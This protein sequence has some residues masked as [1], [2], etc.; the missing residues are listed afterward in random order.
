MAQQ[1]SD[2]GRTHSFR[3][4]FSTKYFLLTDQSENIKA[5]QQTRFND[6]AMS[7]IRNQAMAKL[8]G[9]HSILVTDGAEWSHSRSMLRPSF[10]RNAIADLPVFDRHV[11]HLIERIG[12][13]GEPV[14]LQELFAM[15]TMDSA[16]DFMFG[17]TTNTLNHCDPE[18]AKFSDSF[19][20]ASQKVSK[21]M[22]NGPI[23]NMF[24][25]HQGDEANQY[26]RSYVDKYVKTAL[27]DMGR[28]DQ[29]DKQKYMFLPEL[30]KTGASTEVIRDQVMTMFFA[31]RDS[32]TSVMSYLFWQLARKPDVVEKIQAEIYQYFGGG[33][34]PTFE[35]LRDMRYLNWSIKEALRLNP[36]LS[37]NARSAIR[38]TV[39][40]VGGG[41]DG[42][43]PVFCPEGTVVRWITW[44][45]HRDPAVFGD[46]ANEF[47]PGRWEHLKLT[48]EYLPFSGGPRVCI[49]QQFA[50]TQIA[51]VAVRL[52][53]HFKRI[54]ARDDKP[55]T[56][57]LG[58]TMLLQNG[59]WVS[60]KVGDV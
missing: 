3:M 60:L 4:L 59:C 14:D 46:D 30:V 17:H 13:Q 11:Q 42:K 49:G 33:Q 10:V 15:M 19:D 32:N 40:P 36:P 29:K 20:I 34:E 43:E 47:R 12:D 51:L 58:I 26:A 38:D 16:S 37:I 39:L 8:L 53:Q 18:Y 28:D 35:T 21:A 23:A 45:Q 56:L 5:I 31:G 50:L 44:S 7:P 52:L 22:R 25:D 24:P 54:E 2:Y 27:G 9:R 6:W 55:P 48:W 41:T 1:L 57:K